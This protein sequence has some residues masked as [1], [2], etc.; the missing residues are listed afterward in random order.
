MSQSDLSQTG[1]LDGRVTQVCYKRWGSNCR[2]SRK[3]F[4]SISHTFESSG[5]NSTGEQRSCN[6]VMFHI[7]ERA[8]PF[9][10]DILPV[11]GPEVFLSRDGSL[12]KVLICGRGQI[13]LQNSVRRQQALWPVT[14]GWRC[15]SGWEIS[16]G[17]QCLRAKW[18]CVYLCCVV[19]APELK[20]S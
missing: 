14:G 5:V 2:V 12:V 7:E 4:L 11:I 13:P 10:P 18:G 19:L 9:I 6:S 20:T 17:S 3:E 15:Y 1:F 8:K 16:G